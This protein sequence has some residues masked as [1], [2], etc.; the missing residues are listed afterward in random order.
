MQQPSGKCLSTLQIKTLM[1]FHA[2]TGT[3]Y[4]IKQVEE[5]YRQFY[6]TTAMY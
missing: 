6:P 4:T 1:E 2:P 5:T 3:A